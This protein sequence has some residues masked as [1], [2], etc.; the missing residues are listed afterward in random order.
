METFPKSNYFTE[1]ILWLSF[2]EY[3]LGDIDSYNNYISRFLDNKKRL[4][5][6]QN[7]IYNQILAKVS[8][9]KNKTE[10]VYKYLDL[11]LKYSSSVSEKI[12]IYNQLINYSQNINDYYSLVENLEKLYDVLEDDREK[13]N[14]KLTALEYHKINKNYSYLITEIERLLTLSSFNDKRLF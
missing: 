6:Y 13:K 11:C 7:Y 8:I 1:S 12:N 4:S 5:K 9:D 3:R 2:C 14:V 10:D